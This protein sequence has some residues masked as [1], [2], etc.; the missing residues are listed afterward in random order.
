V[1]GGCQWQLAMEPLDSLFED[2]V[3]P[4]LQVVEA[5]RCCLLLVLWLKGDTLCGG[6]AAPQMILQRTRPSITAAIGCRGCSLLLPLRRAAAVC[7]DLVAQG[8]I[9]SGPRPVLIK[10]RFEFNKLRS[11]SEESVLWGRGA[12]APTLT[13]AYNC[14]CRTWVC[15]S[16]ISDK[17]C[18]TGFNR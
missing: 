17:Y 2:E 1:S 9:Q 6:F 10:M 7:L 18:V 5:H 14:F 12:A 15:R 13:M 11:L 4:L 8:S 16:Y 3:C